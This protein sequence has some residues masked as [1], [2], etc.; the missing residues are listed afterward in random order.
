[1]IVAL[2]CGAE[3]NAPGIGVA[4]APVAGAGTSATGVGG[5]SGTGG[6]S[7]LAG[8][9]GAAIPAESPTWTWSDCGT[10]PS[11]EAPLHVEY[12]RGEAIVGGHPR[13]APPE[14]VTRISALA[15]SADGGTLVSMG[16]VTLAWEVAPVFADSRATYVDHGSPEWPRVDVSPDGRWITIFGDGRRLVSR[17][18]VD[19]PYI[20][21]R[22][23]GAAPC[24]P[25]EAR[26]SP[27]GQW[28]VGADFG[29]GI[30]VFRVADFDAAAGSPVE[31][32]TSLPAPCGQ[33]LEPLLRLD[34]T[35]RVA[36]T[37]DGRTLQTETGA[38]FSTGDW[39]AIAPGTGVPQSHSYSGS[40]EL[41]A[42]GA[43]ILSDCVY[44][45]DIEGHRCAPEAGRF[46]RFSAG[47]SW[48]LAGGTLRHIVSGERQQ[49]DPTAAVG[50]FAPNGD[51]I[52][53]SADNSLTRYCRAD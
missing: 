11:T 7:N 37:P 42:T 24:W 41:S 40:L 31:P 22:G 52:L 13:T 32:V 8:S 10:I 30:D 23:L 29:P 6:S 20:L 53:A 9:S 39:Q 25:A 35:S 4:G 50:I 49:L 14:N 26:F 18:G 1:M 45:H 47:G 46:P 5:T 33:S 27:D 17:A 15:M 28:L 34:A 3:P 2:G 36:F 38:Q 21:L 12:S 48:I 43:S 44:D 51:V 16:G 19:G